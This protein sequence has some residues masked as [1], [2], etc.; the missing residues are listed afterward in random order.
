MLNRV[1]RLLD[2]LPVLL[3]LSSSAALEAQHGERRERKT[4]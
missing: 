4:A 3:S 1:E 2:F